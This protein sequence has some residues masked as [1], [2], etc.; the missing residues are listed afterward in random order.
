MQLVG[1]GEGE[2]RGGHSSLDRA[3]PLE[4]CSTTNFPFELDGEVILAKDL[5][6]S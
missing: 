3:L 4:N 1:D 5:F 6:L 2:V